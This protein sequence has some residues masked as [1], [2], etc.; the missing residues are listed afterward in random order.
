VKKR[1][2][3]DTELSAHSSRVETY[4]VTR[5]HKR[6]SDDRVIAI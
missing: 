4:R 1:K 3:A 2:L 5:F 6:G